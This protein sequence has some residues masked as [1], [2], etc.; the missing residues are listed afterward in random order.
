MK[1]ALALGAL[2]LLPQSAWAADLHL[3]C[4]GGGTA[5]K[6]HSSSVYAQNNQGNSAWGT[7]NSTREVGF[8]DQVNFDMVGDEARLRMPRSMLPVIHGGDDGYMTVKSLKVS[9]REITGTVAVNPINSPKVRI[10]RMTGQISINGK[11][12]AYSGQCQAYDPH[13]VKPQF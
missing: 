3:V 2:V 12:G 13:D 5:N 4:S 11:A 10:D 7:V 1:Y 8:G 9:A 6:H